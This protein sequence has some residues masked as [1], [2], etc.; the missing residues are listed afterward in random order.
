MGTLHLSSMSHSDS[1][2]LEKIEKTLN[3]LTLNNIEPDYKYG[4]INDF[5]DCVLHIKNCKNI[6]IVTG[7][8]I[9]TSCGIPDFRSAG[10]LYDTI[11]KRFPNMTDPT[12]FFSIRYFEKE[13]K[14]FFEMASE[15]WPDNFE[16]SFTHKFMARLDKEKRLK[17]NYTQNIDTLE[18]TA[19][20]TGSNIVQCHGSFA[21]A[22]CR[23]CKKKY[24]G[25][26]IKDKIMA[27]K[28][29]YC[30]IKKGCKGIIK[31]D[32]VFFG[33]GLPQ[34]FFEALEEDGNSNVNNVDLIL[35][36]GS[37]MKVSPVNQVPMALDNKKDNE[38]PTILINCED[39][40]IPLV[41]PK[42]KLLGYGDKI[43]EE[44]EYRMDNDGK[45]QLEEFEKDC[46]TGDLEDIEGLFFREK[47]DEYRFEGWRDD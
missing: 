6:V 40:D 5:N 14:P 28:I 36:I 44:I 24:Q 38:I 2:N 35:V 22:T 45:G 16:P 21:T 43:L 18:Q 4:R 15:I 8:G 3:S 10:G 31:P 1:E 37:T 11:R 34:N 41:T 19:G 12:D 42:M 20:M 46:I 7:A 32:I 26:E 13:P 29:P 25:H 39:V 30:E 17:R 33:E 27:K 9:S 47:P 23:K